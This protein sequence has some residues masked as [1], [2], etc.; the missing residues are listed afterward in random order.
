M[1]NTSQF[2]ELLGK[3]ISVS[4][5]QMNLQWLMIE[6]YKTKNRFHQ[7]HFNSSKILRDSGKNTTV[8]TP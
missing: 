5:H 8:A 7:K 1:D 3:D 6:I 2:K 4:M